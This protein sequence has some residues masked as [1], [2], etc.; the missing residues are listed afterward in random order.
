MPGI[1]AGNP[2]LKPFG[3]IAA[4]LTV[5][6]LSVTGILT[7]VGGST[8]TGDIVPT[9]NNTY[10]VGKATS[11]WKDVYASGTVYAQNVSVIGTCTNCGSSVGLTL[12]FVTHIVPNANNTY[13][14]GASTSSLRNI[15]ASGTAYLGGALVGLTGTSP[16]V[17]A[18]ANVLDIGV[19]SSTWHDLYASGTLYASSTQASSYGAKIPAY[20]FVLCPSCGLT[21][22]TNGTTIGLAVNG[23][24]IVTV[25]TTNVTLSGT[26]IGSTNNLRDVGSQTVA[27]KDAYVSGTIYSEGIYSTS[28]IG[29]VGHFVCDDETGKMW[30]NA[31]NCT[32]SSAFFKDHIASLS[33]ADAL[34]EVSKLRAVTYRLKGKDEEQKG[35]IAEEVAA[36]DPTLVDWEE[37]TPDHLAWTKA[38]YPQLVV[39][40]DG[41]TLVPYSVDYNRFS[42]IEAAAIQAQQN[43]LD[44]QDARITALETGKTP[45]AQTTALEHR[46]GVLEWLM[47]IVSRILHLGSKVSI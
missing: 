32:V 47:S 14:L 9:A 42:V 3:G 15:Y 36:I 13:D 39:V 43:Q 46:V 29:T 30:S 1:F 33:P 6:A 26:L 45:V 2:I 44:A 24:N 37:P 22:N 19:S 16:L 40:R 41:K 23:A 20:N 21:T 8:V 10:S 18:Q 11:S 25:S 28:S 17:P 5:V 4:A 7:L 27:W 12:P 31:V 35:F 34:A 38:H